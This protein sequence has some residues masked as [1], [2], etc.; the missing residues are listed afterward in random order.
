MSARGPSAAE[1]PRGVPGD[2]AASRRAVP[3]AS[4]PTTSS[5]YRPDDPPGDL[6]GLFPSREPR[7]ADPDEPR[8][9]DLT[10]QERPGEASDPLNPRPEPEHAVPPG[11]PVDLP[12][13]S[14]R[15]EQLL[16]TAVSWLIVLFTTLLGALGGLTYSSVKTATYTATAS[17]IVT[18]AKG[19]QVQSDPIVFAN[20]YAHVVT[21]PTVLQPALTDAG[22]SMSADEARK[23]LTVTV[24]SGSSLITIQA[25][26][27]SGADAAALANAAANGVVTYGTAQSPKTGLDLLIFTP[28]TTPTSSSRPDRA[29]NVFVGALIGLAVGGVVVLLIRRSRRVS[30]GAAA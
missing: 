22:I 15:R 20:N 18:P 25:T 26:A 2:P 6:S 19:A 8:V 14:L 30:A 23:H 21:S 13:P 27:G 24:P 17:V 7:R 12:Q 5:G 9:I 11:F 10:Y 3:P 29:L 4:R 16:L 1:P 28:A